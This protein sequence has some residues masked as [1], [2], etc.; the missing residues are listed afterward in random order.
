MAYIIRADLNRQNP[1]MFIQIKIRFIKIH[2]FDSKQIPQQLFLD[3]TIFQTQRKLFLLYMNSDLT[4]V[5]K[6]L[7]VM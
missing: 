2:R 3:L 6:L 4:I 1:A 7:F 5:T